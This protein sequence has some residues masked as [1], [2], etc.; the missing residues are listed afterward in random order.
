[1]LTYNF[2][3]VFR[4][5]A[6]DKPFSFLKRNGFS[7]NFATKISNN[8]SKRINLS[9]LERLCLILKCAPNDFFQWDQDETCEIEESHPLNE[10]KKTKDESD[11]MTTLNSLPLGKMKEIN[12]LIKE[13]IKK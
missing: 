1:M 2:K 8:R 12:N 10:L 11:L 4:A 5:R 9:E 6:I 7:D 13:N 3:R